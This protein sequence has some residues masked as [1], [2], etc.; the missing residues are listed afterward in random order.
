MGGVQRHRESGEAALRSYRTL[1]ED[2]PV[3]YLSTDAHRRIRRANRQAHRMLGY[4]EGQL[5]G[6]RTIDLYAAADRP[7]AQ[8]L[9]D[10]FFEGSDIHGEEL[11]MR[12]ADGSERIVLISA[13]GERDA[14]GRVM[15]SRAMAVD[16]TGRKR[17]ERT[18]QSRAKLEALEILA[19]TVAHDLN[20]LLTAIN[21]L[22]E[23]AREEVPA[24]TRL[25]ED[26]GRVL[27]LG[28]KAVRLN[29]RLVSFARP[30]AAA[31]AAT[32]VDLAHFFA[33]RR[34]MLADMTGPK[35]ELRVWLEP[36]LGPVAGNA[37]DLERIV[38]NLL[39]NARDAMPDGG[40]LSV[41]AVRD[42]LRP[43]G[44]R[45]DHAGRGRLMLTFEDSGHGMDVETVHN[46]FEPFYSTKPAGRG[47]GLGLASVRE[48]VRRLGGDV[49]IDSAPGEGTRVRILLPGA[50][51]GGDAPEATSIEHTG[52]P[53]RSE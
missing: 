46:A 42:G 37:D 43:A 31:P 17:L 10:R 6:M 41:E 15:C 13:V 49:S 39:T 20:N 5:V 16:I 30:A 14:S 34:P 22:A 21:G 18:L 8:W 11:R 28:R 27:Q 26:L 29:D 45:G 7:R 32:G 40:S 23:L 35:V 4:G 53:S 24:D 38:V 44:E 51:A 52:V 3:A 48:I 25:H 2:A 33:E 50:G 36:G 9:M 12:A 1:F 47:T 19:G